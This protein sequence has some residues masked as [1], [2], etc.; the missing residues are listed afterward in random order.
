ML[1]IT[2]MAYIFVENISI[3]LIRL[4]ACKANPGTHA[5]SPLLG[6]PDETRTHISQSE[7][8]VA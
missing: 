5:H 4:S 6:T 8:L 1:P 7:N 2:P 3:E